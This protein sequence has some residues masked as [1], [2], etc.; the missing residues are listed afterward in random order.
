MRIRS[1]DVVNFAIAF[2]VILAWIALTIAGGWLGASYGWLAG[3]AGAL[4]GFII[5]P[6]VQFAISFGRGHGPILTQPAD[7]RSPRSTQD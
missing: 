7:C 2:F 1:S 5:V 4:A 3:I 6:I